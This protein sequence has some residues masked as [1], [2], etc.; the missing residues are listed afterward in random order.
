MCLLVYQAEL[1]LVTVEA[2][3][4]GN[5]SLVCIELPIGDATV[6]DREGAVLRLVSG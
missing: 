6:S 4:T 5:L 1:S 2:D 3:F